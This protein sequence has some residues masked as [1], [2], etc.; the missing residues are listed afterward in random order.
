MEN[1]IIRKLVQSLDVVL[2]PIVE[3]AD[4]SI[5]LWFGNDKEEWQ[6][7]GI[8]DAVT[9]IIART[10]TRAFAGIELARNHQV[11]RSVPV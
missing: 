9:D 10:T 4:Y 3:E 5:N 2:Q 11:R 6:P 1:V 7:F 8:K